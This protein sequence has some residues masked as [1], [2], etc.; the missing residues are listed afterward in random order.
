VRFGV[1]F[2]LAWLP[3]LRDRV[4]EPAREVVLLGVLLLRDPG[5]ED[6]RVAMLRTLG[7]RHSSHRDHRCVS[8]RPFAGG[9]PDRREETQVTT[10]CPHRRE[11]PWIRIVISSFLSLLAGLLSTLA[12]LGRIRAHLLARG[13]RE[14]WRPSP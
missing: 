5:E 9:V 6:V 3:V 7:D 8:R 13:R 10:T 4:L 2:R 12:R 11:I 14:I 1:G